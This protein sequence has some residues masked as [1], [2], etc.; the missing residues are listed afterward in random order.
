MSQINFKANKGDVKVI[1]GW[2][3]PL[4]YYYLTI[5]KDDETIFDGFDMLGFCRE[6]KKLEHL[7][8]DLG[9]EIPP[10]TLAL[11]DRREGNVIY[12][13][14]GTSWNVYVC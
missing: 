1:T 14:N 4:G 8:R 3:P 13:Y 7:I 10:E 6:I 12:E 5:L 2:D 9:I 11:I